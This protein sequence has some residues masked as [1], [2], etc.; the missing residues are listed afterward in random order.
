M[1]EDDIGQM[2]QEV[3]SL[4]DST[5]A[6]HSDRGVLERQV[7]EVEAGHDT[8]LQTATSLI[9]QATTSVDILHALPP[10][11]Q[12]RARQPTSYADRQ[13]LYSAGEGV[14][15]RLLTAPALLDKEL[16]RE[17]SQRSAL[18][19]IRVTRL[20]PMQTYVVDGSVALVLADSVAGRRSSSLIRVPE[21]LH[22]LSR[23]YESLWN[24]AS[25]AW[26]RVVLAGWA[27]AELAPRILG[28]LRAGTTDEV[29]ARE[30]KISVRTYRRYVAEIMSLLG[31]SS[32]FQAG[33]RAAALG[34][35]PPAAGPRKDNRA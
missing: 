25:P 6:L 23:L 19:G 11:T 17:Q 4:L 8:I 29:A 10:S 9:T 12:E 18:V 2:L 1:S 33:V 27:G 26:G 15:V 3:K 31:A 21:V 5:V 30:M 7:T 13:V 34:L 20:P 32:R 28:A 14:S 24:N 22:T 16:V 35:L